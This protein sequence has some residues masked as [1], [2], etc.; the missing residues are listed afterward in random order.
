MRRRAIALLAVIAAAG[1]FTIG[2]AGKRWPSLEFQ[3]PA[4]EPG[5]LVTA[6][7]DLTPAHYVAPPRPG[8]P[9]IEIFLVPIRLARTV[10]SPDEPGVVHAVSI[11]ADANWRGVA[12]FRVPDVPAGRYAGAYRISETFHSPRSTRPLDLQGFEL[13]IH[14][15]AKSATDSFGVVVAVAGAA[16]A[17]AVLARR[18]I[19]G[20]PPK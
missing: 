18:R 4:A 6:R 10:N 3:P 20:A 17:A 12:S 19:G 14:P 9:R 13:R 1:V 8:G 15:G 7:V 5:E 2:S 16:L 11:R